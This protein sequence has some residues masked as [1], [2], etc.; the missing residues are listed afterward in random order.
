MIIGI[1]VLLAGAAYYML[2]MKPA[3]SASATAAPPKPVAGFVVKLDPMLH[4]PRRRSLPQAGRRAPGRRRRPRKELDGSKALDAAITVFSGKD[5]AKVAENTT[6]E[7]LKKELSKEVVDLYEDEVMDVY[8]TE[9]VMQ[10]PHPT[11]PTDR[12]TGPD[13][14]RGS[15]VGGRTDEPRTHAHHRST[16]RHGITRSAQRSGTCRCS[17]QMRPRLSDGPA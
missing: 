11:T 3:A 6:R 16:D 8:F 7:E 13:T 14:G 9:F 4:Q 15:A 2:V 12:R 10:W 5:M 17:P 1:V